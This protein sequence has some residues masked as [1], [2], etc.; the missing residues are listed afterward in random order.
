MLPVVC[1]FFNWHDF[2]PPRCSV[3]MFDVVLLV[4]VAFMGIASFRYVGIMIHNSGVAETWAAVVEI[5]IVVES[6]LCRGRSIMMLCSCRFVRAAH[7]V[8]SSSSIA[9]FHENFLC[10]IILL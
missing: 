6:S 4:V 5:F 2:C 1:M 10:M 8:S 9:S 7:A 3:S